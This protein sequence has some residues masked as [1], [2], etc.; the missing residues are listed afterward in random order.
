MTI[1]PTVD[2]E[3]YRAMSAPPPATR[4]SQAAKI[5]CSALVVVV[6]LLVVGISVTVGWRPFIGP[7]ARPL[8]ARRFEAT[9]QRLERG[10]YIFTALS[11]CV[12]CHSPLEKSQRGFPP[13]AS[14]MGAG[15]IFPEGSLPGRIVAPNL[16]PDTQTG[17]GNWTDDQIARAIREG[18]GHDGRALFPAMPYQN[19][20]EMSDEDVASV[21]V[22]MRSLPPIHHE[23]PKSEITFPVKY[24]INSL[25]QPLTSN[26]KTPDPS[27]R[28]QW[29]KYLVRMTSCANCHTAHTPDGKPVSG[30]DFAGGT[31][32]T[33]EGE[34]TA[35]ANLT[36][37]ASGISYYDEALFIRT[38]R[39]GFVGARPLSSVMP[40]VIYR[41][42]SDDDLKAI[43]AYLKTLAPVHHRVDNS[44]PPTYCRLC[45]QKHGAGDQN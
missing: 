24:L 27:D 9:S 8:T 45:R 26:V 3:K 18:I 6:V 28:L 42:L 11:G 5:L 39:T 43:F 32:I 41:N 29:G 25:P 36:P 7:A 2:T 33:I 19:F 44:L 14:M 15:Q 38:L 35:G 40:F 1:S 20:R 21:I 22:F 13:V 37:D 10:R 31:A 17:S 12:H 30:M 16:T 23:L 4:R 34:T